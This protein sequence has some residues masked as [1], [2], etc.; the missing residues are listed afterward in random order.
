MYP[1]FLLLL[2]LTDGE[3]KDTIFMQATRIVLRI[4]MTN[5]RLVRN[6]WQPL[7]SNVIH[8]QL[9]SE[10]RGTLFEKWAGC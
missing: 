9:T 3:H 7:L 10:E 4:S 5:V 1:Q 6:N 8:L 2:F